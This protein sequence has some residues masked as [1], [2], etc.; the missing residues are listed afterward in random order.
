MNKFVLLIAFLL[1][2]FTSTLS[3]ACNDPNCTCEAE[4]NTKR[5]KAIDEGNESEE[6]EP[7]GFHVLPP[8]VLGMVVARTDGKG[9]LALSATQSGLLDIVVDARSRLK[10]KWGTPTDVIMHQIRAQSDRVQEVI[11]LKGTHISADVFT[12]L[13]HCPRLISL[14]LSECTFDQG[15]DLTQ[16]ATFIRLE[17]LWISNFGEV[18][19]NLNFCAG[20]TALHELT[21]HNLRNLGDVSGIQALPN[22]R[23]VQTWNS[24]TQ[25]RFNPVIAF[26]RTNNLPVNW[27]LE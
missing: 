11:F 20:L 23:M 26:R 18:V 14:T 24:T 21:L 19:P 8:E 5:A 22:L 17:K 16:L 6:E 27:Q 25:A 1:S 4:S 12:L 3:F 15:R 10:F 7:V 9:A 13:S 2:T